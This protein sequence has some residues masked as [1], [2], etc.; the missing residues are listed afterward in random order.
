MAAELQDQMLLG[1]RTN[2]TKYEYIY[3]YIHIY[4]NTYIYVMNILKELLVRINRNYWLEY[5]PHIYKLGTHQLLVL[6]QLK[7]LAIHTPGMFCYLENDI[8]NSKDI[9]YI[10]NKKQWVQLNIHLL[11]ITAM[12]LL[13]KWLMIS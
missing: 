6:K 12:S 2:R 1:L 11:L 3:I 5:F 10:K 9:Q 7:V 8:V 4:T 13:L